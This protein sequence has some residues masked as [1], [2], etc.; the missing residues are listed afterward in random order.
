MDNKT[1][2]T[3]KTDAESSGR[4][5]LE[6]LNI[7]AGDFSTVTDEDYKIQVIKTQNDALQ[8]ALTEEL[9]DSLNSERFLGTHTAYTDDTIKQHTNWK[10]EYWRE[11]SVDYLY[12]TIGL[13]TTDTTNDSIGMNITKIEN[14]KT[15]ST[16]D[17]LAYVTRADL[18]ERTFD[19]DTA[20]DTY[21]SETNPGE[22]G[23]G[24][25]TINGVTNSNNK[26]TINLNGNEGFEVNEGSTLNI[27][28]TKITNG[29]VALTASTENGVVNLE[30][31]E[32]SGNNT[33]IRT[34]G[35]VNATGKTK[36]TDD[37]ILLGGEFNINDTKKTVIGKVSGS[38]DSILGINNSTLTVNNRISGVETV[39][40][41]SKLNLPDETLLT[42]GLRVDKESTVNTINNKTMPLTLNNLTMTDNFNMQLDVDLAKLSMDT[43][44]ANSYDLA[45]YILKRERNNNKL[46]R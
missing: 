26:S 11:T 40:N 23:E 42:G 41:N 10:D 34:S 1:A 6:R 3:F 45:N 25:F 44:R 33:G 8:L 12:G 37:I 19:F 43:V 28:N 39:L 29:S 18:D 4:I 13:A 36:I 16:L 24:T 38:A 31:V 32:I 5:T 21:T 15:D 35:I 30:D 2:D 14:V 27:N 17:T 22:V 20:G 9:S 7:L 46:C